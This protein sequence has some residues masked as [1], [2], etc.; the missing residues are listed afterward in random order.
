MNWPYYFTWTAQNHATPLSLDACDDY[1]F[2]NGDHKVLDLSSISYQASFGLRNQ[3]ITDSISHQLAAF[4]LSSPKH[5]FTLKNEVSDKLLK[6]LNLSGKIF[7]TVSGAESVENALKM[8][9]QIRKAPKVLARQNSYHGATLAALSVTGD[10]RHDAHQTLDDWTIRIP[11]HL[12]DPDGSRLEAIILEHG[13]DNIAAF[14]LE[15]TTGGNGVFSPPEAWYQEV[16]RLCDH[17]GIMLILDEVICGF[18][19]TGKVFGFHHY[20]FLKPDLVCLSKGISGGYIPFGALYTNN[21]IAQFYEKETLSAGLT[22]YAHPLGL[23]ALQGVQ[24][25]T[26]Q[27]GFFEHVHRLEKILKDF[28]KSLKDTIS[29][30]RVHGALMAIDLKHQLNINMAVSKGL[31]F[32]IQPDRLILAPALTMPADLLSAGL[33]QLEELIRAK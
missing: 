30:Y 22:N 28:G 6:T 13:P 1:H 12:E 31:Y 4:S 29:D 24:K 2:L 32:I 25:I 7:Y 14:C 17:Y 8:A 20:P 23:A 15:T 16:Q 11:D 19:R 3:V 5:T 21:K 33:Q 27:E 18:G 10:W 9:R 26:E